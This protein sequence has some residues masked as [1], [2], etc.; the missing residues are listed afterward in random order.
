MVAATVLLCMM[1]YNSQALALWE[2]PYLISALHQ[3]MFSEHFCE[4]SAV[5]D[6]GKPGPRHLFKCFV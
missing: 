1:F 5:L 4:I 3:M 2:F 6:K